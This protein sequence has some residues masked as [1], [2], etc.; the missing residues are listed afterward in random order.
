MDLRRLGSVI[1]RAERLPCEG[2][3]YEGLS[4]GELFRA[5]PEE[6]LSGRAVRGRANTDAKRM[7]K[8]Y[9]KVMQAVSELSQLTHGAP[10]GRNMPLPRDDARARPELPQFFYEFAFGR[11]NRSFRRGSGS[12][13]AGTAASAT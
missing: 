11:C 12:A 4:V 2:R 3:D 9:A 13:A 1:E 10:L 7:M 6:I 8:A 5:W